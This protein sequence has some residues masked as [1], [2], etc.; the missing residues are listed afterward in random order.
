MLR[1]DNAK[2]F[3]AQSAD[4]YEAKIREAYRAGWNDAERNMME[5]AEALVQVVR[6][7]RA[8]ADRMELAEKIREVT[9]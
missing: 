5:K 6:E 7:Q 9:E 3:A 2:K 4:W 8:K 1:D